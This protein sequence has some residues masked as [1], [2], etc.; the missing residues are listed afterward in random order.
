MSVGPVQEVHDAKQAEAVVEVLVVEEVELLRRGEREVVPAVIVARDE[1]DDHDPR[2]YHGD[3]RSGQ[4]EALHLNIAV[5]LQRL[6]LRTYREDGQNIPEK[7]LERMTVRCCYGNGVRPL[8][9]LFV[10]VL[11]DATMM[12]QP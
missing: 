7:V 2:P 9:V 10:H 1:Y 4:D 5:N 3:V 11:V 8:V 6:G 12:K